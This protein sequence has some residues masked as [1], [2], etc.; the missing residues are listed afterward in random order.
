MCFRAWKRAVPKHLPSRVPQLGRSP[1]EPRLQ[2]TGTAPYRGH[3]VGALFRKRYPPTQLL[4]DCER[5]ARRSLLVRLDCPWVDVSTIRLVVMK[6]GEV[7]PIT[8]LHK[9]T[10]CSAAIYL[11]LSLKGVHARA[12]AV[13]LFNSGVLRLV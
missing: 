12:Q 6:L 13:L 11:P 10:R 1:E 5:R 4:I 8:D 3:G 9:G 2:P 7:V